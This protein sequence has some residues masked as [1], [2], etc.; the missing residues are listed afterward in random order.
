MHVHQVNFLF[1]C[2]LHLQISHTMLSL[3]ALKLLMAASVVT[4]VTCILIY[5]ARAIPNP[6]RSVPSSTDSHVHLSEKCR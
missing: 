4:L 6:D 3:G 1:C 2:L 5:S